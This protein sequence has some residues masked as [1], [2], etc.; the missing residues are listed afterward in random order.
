MRK[1]FLEKE[2]SCP[3]PHREQKTLCLPVSLGVPSFVAPLSLLYTSRSHPESH[4]EW[5][6]SGEI[7]RLPTTGLKIKP[8]TG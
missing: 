4:N 6:Q 2:V 3:E 8:Q 5:P 7:T 1:H